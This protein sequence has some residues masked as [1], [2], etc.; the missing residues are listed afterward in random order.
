MWAVGTVGLV[1]AGLAALWLGGCKAAVGLSRGAGEGLRRWLVQRSRTRPGSLAAGLALA[2]LDPG[3]RLAPRAALA[4]AR[5]A[6]LDPERAGWLAIGAGAGPLLAGLVGLLVLPAERPSLVLGAVVLAGLGL[7]RTGRG[8]A[9]HAGT[10]LGGAALWAIGL[11]T[12]GVGAGLLGARTALASG[13]PLELLV[14][15]ALGAGTAALSRAAGSAAAVGLGLA[16][17]GAVD[18]L[19]A[20]AWLIGVQAVAPLRAAAGL[21][22]DARRAALFH[23]AWAALASAVGLVVLGWVALV[24]GDVAVYRPL[25]VLFGFLLLQGLVG[26]VLLGPLAP[27]VARLV[28]QRVAPGSEDEGDAPLDPL[29]QP[30]PAL[31]AGELR[32]ELAAVF[33]AMR[34][35]A[36]GTLTGG[37]LTEFRVRRDY[38]PLPE[39]SEQLASA[40]EAWIRV[41]RPGEELAGE[42]RR[43]AVSARAVRRAAEAVIGLRALGEIHASREATVKLRFQQA[44]LG[45]LHLVE[46]VDPA[47]GADPAVLQRE[48]QG[49]ES[50]VREVEM[51]VLAGTQSGRLP[52]EEL[53]RAAEHL[54]G[55]VALARAAVEAVEALRGDDP[56][57]AAPADAAE[58]AVAA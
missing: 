23:G 22:P 10:W 13:A 41:A 30:L 29:A 34:T 1:A 28:D 14:G 31:A 52:V 4:L 21:G 7:A 18:G 5:P 40:A 15:L 19:T 49:L 8:R 26:A 11:Q 48:L 37:K 33:G 2:A 50:Q 6:R 43:V 27:S 57:P 47:R 17:G 45:A 20:A 25:P 3:G 46:G 39:R 55:L 58:P 24:S 9:A 51:R 36:H 16:A 44:R 42:A 12:L 35:F 53:S 54:A 32:E 56:V 38:L